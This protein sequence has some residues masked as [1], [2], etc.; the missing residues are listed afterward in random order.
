[1][2][3][4]SSSVATLPYNEAVSI[5]LYGFE[6]VAT[7]CSARSCRLLFAPRYPREQ[8]GHKGQRYEAGFHYQRPG[9]DA[10]SLSISDTITGSA[11]GAISS[12]R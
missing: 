7:L 2:V 8:S 4:D 10:G 1:M 5:V 9:F 12:R 6:R 3:Q 11:S